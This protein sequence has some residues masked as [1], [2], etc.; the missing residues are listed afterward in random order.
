MNITASGLYLEILL[1]IFIF[2]YVVRILVDAAGIVKTSMDIR[3][4]KRL[5]KLKQKRA[6]DVAKLYG[7]TRVDPADGDNPADES[8][9]FIQNY[10]TV[11]K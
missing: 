3:E 5:L 7:K 6:E 2:T 8:G 4:K 1:T 11:P 9:H 10:G